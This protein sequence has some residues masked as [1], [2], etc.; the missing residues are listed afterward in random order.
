MGAACDSSALV[1]APLCQASK[2]LKAGRTRS[3]RIGGGHVKKQVLGGQLALCVVTMGV[4]GPESF[5]PS[6]APQWDPLTPPPP[7]PRVL[8]VMGL[9]CD[10][11]SGQQAAW[12]CHA[13]LI[14]TEPWRELPS[15]LAILRVRNRNGLCSCLIL[16]F[17]FLSSQLS[18]F[19][20]TTAWSSNCPDLLERGSLSSAWCAPAPSPEWTAQGRGGNRPA[21]AGP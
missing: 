19:K 6:P 7:A 9:S 8:S 15:G 16:F 5:T 1:G 21:S 20:R 17:S 2:A 18:I 11:H 12:L 13:S 3:V 4:P 14:R 10:Q